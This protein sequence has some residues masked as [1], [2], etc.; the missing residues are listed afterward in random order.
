MTISTTS[1]ALSILLELGSVDIAVCLSNGDE[2]RSGRFAMSV[3]DA[4][5]VV[6]MLAPASSVTLN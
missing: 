1:L 4:V 3:V 5:P 2:R 6:L